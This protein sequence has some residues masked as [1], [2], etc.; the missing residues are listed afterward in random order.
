MSREV[1]WGMGNEI[2][3]SHPQISTITH[4]DGLKMCF[5]PSKST[6]PK[7]NGKSNN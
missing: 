2:C 6:F 5:E 1:V 4:F 3:T 7:L